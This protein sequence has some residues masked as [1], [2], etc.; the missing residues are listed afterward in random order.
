[1]DANARELK[2]PVE[3]MLLIRVYSC[4]SVV[5]TLIR[6]YSRSFVVKTLIRVYSRSFAVKNSGALS[7]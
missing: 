1:M 7:F 4:S 6:V 2:E 5:K 3:M